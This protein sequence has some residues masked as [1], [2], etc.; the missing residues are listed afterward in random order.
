MFILI[1]HSFPFKKSFG[2]VILAGIWSMVAIFPILFWAE[3]PALA[4]ECDVFTQSEAKFEQLR[5]FRADHVGTISD[6]VYRQVALDYLASA[7]ACYQA[8]MPPHQ[9]AIT[10]TIFI[11]EGGLWPPGIEG[12]VGIQA[13]LRGTKWSVQGGGEIVDPENPAP[14]GLVTYSYMSSVVT[15]TVEGLKEFGLSPKNIDVRTDL[16]VICGPGKSIT[17]EISSAFEAWEAVINIDF[18]EIAESGDVPSNEK[19]GSDNQ[20]IGDIRIGAHEFFSNEVPLAH[21]YFPPDRAASRNTIAGDIHF[22]KGVKWSCDPEPDRRDIGLVALHE[23]GHAIGL[24]HQPLNEALAVMNAGYNS[25]FSVLQ[26]DDILGGE[27]VYGP[28]SSPNIDTLPAVETNWI[29][30]FNRDLAPNEWTWTPGKRV[31]IVGNI[32]E[33]SESYLTSD[34]LSNTNR[35]LYVR[36]SFNT[37]F[38]N[39]AFYEGGVI[40]YQL[41]SQTDWYSITR[42]YFLKNG[43]NGILTNPNPS[44]TTVLEGREAFAGNSI[45]EILS[46]VDLRQLVPEDQA[47]KLRF[48]FATNS[49]PL[50]T[51]GTPAWTLS[52]IKVGKPSI[53]YFPVMFK[54]GSP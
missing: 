15:H 5:Q 14:G 4:R 45:G 36:H 6:E 7:E 32:G 16:E 38:N 46:T 50:N 20:I 33:K 49:S 42:E 31:W 51:P 28:K 54:N 39:S 2:I 1:F 44:S 52:E 12:P 19:P 21:G 47:F 37:E 29:R 25:S 43:Y 48:R 27:R 8:T 11:D 18:E 3:E 23:I 13:V 53:Y 35:I 9:E 40:E 41:V 34:V 10:S 26:P 30:D 24:D 22:N 17:T